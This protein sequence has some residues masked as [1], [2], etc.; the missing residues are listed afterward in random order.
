MSGM[1][2]R[3]T[4]GNWA[5]TA[6]G[7]GGGSSCLRRFPPVSANVPCLVSMRRLIG[8][9]DDRWM[10]MSST[11]GGDGDDDGDAWKRSGGVTRCGNLRAPL[12][13]QRSQEG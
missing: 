9:G 4:V 13:K 6:S 12:G 7:L 11:G 8:K 2:A 10:E 1:R 3:L 5:G